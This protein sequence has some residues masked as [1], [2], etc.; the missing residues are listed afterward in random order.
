MTLADATILALPRLARRVRARLPVRITLFGSSTTEGIGASDPAHGYEAVIGR[1]LRPHM[2]GG[3]SLVNRG[4]G[5]NGATEMHARIEDVLADNA[6]LVLWQGG[7]NDVWQGVPVARFGALTRADLRVLRASGAELAMVDQQW[8]KMMEECPAF[9]AFR[10]AVA[11]IATDLGIPVFPRYES[12]K[13][14]CAERG[15]TRDELSPDGLHM[16]DV[17]YALLGNAIGAWLLA[18]METPSAGGRV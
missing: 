7:T 17:G 3:V 6:D 13:R 2:P 15:M 5:G 10:A 11:A 12:M 8:C 4:I 14:W 9:P 18:L 16:G 1:T